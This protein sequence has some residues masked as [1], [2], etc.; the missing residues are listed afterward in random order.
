MGKF[1]V[2]SKLTFTRVV[3]TTFSPYRTIFVLGV[4]GQTALAVTGAGVAED[5]VQPHLV[6]N[7]DGTIYLINSASACDKSASE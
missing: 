6:Y 3:S 5:K 1:C 7:Y 4:H 2:G